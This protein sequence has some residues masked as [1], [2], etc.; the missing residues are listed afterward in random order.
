MGVRLLFLPASTNMT[1]TQ[2]A[3][4]KGDSKVNV[5]Q[6]KQRSTAVIFATVLV[7]A[8]C[9]KKVVPPT[10]PPPPPPPP[11]P[12]A[13]I[14]ANPSAIQAGQSST[15]TWTTTNATQVMITG[16]GT[17]SN[18]GSRSISPTRSTDYTITATAANGAYVQATTRV[19]VTQP[20]P[21]PRAAAPPS[22]TDEELFAQN[23]HDVYFD[24]DKYDL[25]TADTS[26]AEQDASFLKT[27]P[28]MKL[29]IEGHC[30]DRGSAEYNIALGQ[31]RA[32]S[33]KKALTSDG[34]DASRIRIISYGEEKPFCTEESEACWQQNRRDHL[35]LDR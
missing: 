22:M 14:S 5:D 24:Y 13:S 25:R 1:S 7:L 10:P 21:P 35:Q 19:T 17:V 26:T 8:G 28:N 12:T 9:H 29:L 27:H 11:A 31:N 32:E 16:L 30:D 3:I 4:P 33:L 20:P 18:T 2:K 6:L 34:I 23:V 15:V